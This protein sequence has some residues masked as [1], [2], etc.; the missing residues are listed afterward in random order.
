MTANDHSLSFNRGVSADKLLLSV[1]AKAARGTEHISRY[2]KGESVVVGGLESATEYD[3]SVQR[4][5]RHQHIPAKDN[6]RCGN[7]T[8][9][10]RKVKTKEEAVKP[11]R[12][13][14]N[15][16]PKA[17]LVAAGHCCKQTVKGNV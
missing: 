10:D 3:I 13:S 8:K 5:Y 16:K 2:Q 11:S 14:S 15:G 9:L 1:S 4:C 7:W 17:K 12:S 6:L